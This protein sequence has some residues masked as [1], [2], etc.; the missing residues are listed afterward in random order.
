MDVVAGLLGCLGF[1]IIPTLFTWMTAR[2]ILGPTSRAAK[3]GRGQI[4]FRIIDF[5][6]LVVE[7][8]AVAAVAV[9]VTQPDEPV[10]R[11][12]LLLFGTL[13]TLALWVG[14]RAIERRKV[15][16]DFRLSPLALRKTRQI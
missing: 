16:C 4:Q 2:W 15:V 8:Q 5:F 6:C 11:T 12:S 1:L 7:M 10:F 13:S 9:G 14:G 3:T